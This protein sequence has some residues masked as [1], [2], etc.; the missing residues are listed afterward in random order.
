MWDFGRSGLAFEVYGCLGAAHVAH[1]SAGKLRPILANL[2]E[3]ALLSLSQHLKA[4]EAGVH[5]ES[6]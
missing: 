1:K 4:Q 5:S 6:C 3:D 2:N